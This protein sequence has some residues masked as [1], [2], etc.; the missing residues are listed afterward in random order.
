MAV[1]EQWSRERGRDWER[2]GDKSGRLK[3]RKRLR[4]CRLGPSC[5]AV[6][7]VARQLGKVFPFQ[8]LLQLS[9]SLAP[10]ESSVDGR[11][12]LSL[13]FIAPCDVVVQ[14]RPFGRYELRQ[15]ISDALFWQ[16]ARPVS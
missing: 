9:E 13:R 16:V 6:R 4:L 11:Q 12:E 14:C 10:P 5:K 8:V 3:E 15:D 7:Y 1:F 2:S